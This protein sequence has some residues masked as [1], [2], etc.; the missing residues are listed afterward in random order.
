[1][2][3]NSKLNVFK[4]EKIQNAVKRM[5]LKEFNHNE[6]FPTI[7]VDKIFLLCIPDATRI[8]EAKL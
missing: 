2:N 1:M 4:L 5:L 3:K 8:D 7:K 6:T